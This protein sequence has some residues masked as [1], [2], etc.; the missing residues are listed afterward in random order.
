MRKRTAKD[1]TATVPT[2]Y[3]MA[4]RKAMISDCCNMAATY[5][6]VPDDSGKRKTRRQYY[7]SQC[8]EKCE[9]HEI[10]VRVPVPVEVKR[11][12]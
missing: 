10:T 6:T 1:N 9:V 11:V 4:S 8:H 5:R 7:C 12:E 2:I 3:E